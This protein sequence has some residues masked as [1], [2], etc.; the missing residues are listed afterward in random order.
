MCALVDADVAGI[1]GPPNVAIAAFRFLLAASSTVAFLIGRCAARQLSTVRLVCRSA[2]IPSSREHPSLAQAIAAED[3]GVCRS[4]S[5]SLR[6]TGRGKDYG[7]FAP[8]VPSPAATSALDLL[9]V[10][11][12]VPFA[13]RASMGTT[14]YEVLFAMATSDVG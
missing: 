10:C 6:G 1:L 2:E 9:H 11:G 8:L 14:S 13:T 4:V 5:A 3:N 7:H 12:L